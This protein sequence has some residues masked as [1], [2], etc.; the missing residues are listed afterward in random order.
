LERWIGWIKQIV[1]GGSVSVGA[2]GEKSSPFKT[3]KGL[4]QGDP[5]SPIPF[6]LVADVLTKMLSKAAKEK[7]V[8][9]L[10]DQFRPGGL[11][12][13]SMQMTLYFSP[14]VTLM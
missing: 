2:N 5:L 3:G 1:Y 6:N 12:H 8:V 13:C 7:L 14:Y 9:G 11:C 10:L 4:R